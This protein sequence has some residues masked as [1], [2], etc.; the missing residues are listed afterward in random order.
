MQDNTIIF[1]QDIIVLLCGPIYSVY[2]P[3][4]IV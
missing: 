3:S 2:N 1:I 4:D